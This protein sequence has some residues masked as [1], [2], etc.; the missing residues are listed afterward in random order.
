M[1][2]A[3]DTPDLVAYILRYLKAYPNA[4]D[5]ADGVRAWWLRDSGATPAEVS[6][7]LDLLVSS[8]KV[9]RVSRPTG[10]VFRRSARALD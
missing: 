4:C 5:S 9:E 10:D 2:A 6:A 3:A 8:G 1:S 7:A